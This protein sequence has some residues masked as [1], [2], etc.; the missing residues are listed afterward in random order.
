M[1]E[2]NLAS[3]RR[4]PGAI[5]L[6]LVWTVVGSLGLAGQQGSSHTRSH[7]WSWNPKLGEIC[8][9]SVAWSASSLRLV[10][11]PVLPGFWG[12]CGHFGHISKFVSCYW[13]NLLW[14][15]ICSVWGL[16]CKYRLQRCDWSYVIYRNFP[17]PKSPKSYPRS[18]GQEQGG[19][20]GIMTNTFPEFG[21]QKQ[22]NLCEF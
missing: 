2:T 21:R 22:A 12:N 11:Y 4:N 19:K 14:K 20:L 1:R 17:N 9:L 7:S 16:P 10:K 5:F 3:G 13:T 8:E 6:T 18:K 15:V